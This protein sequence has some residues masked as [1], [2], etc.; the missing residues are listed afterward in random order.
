MIENKERLNR[1]NQDIEKK[2][3]VLKR[4]EEKLKNLQDE[5]EKMKEHI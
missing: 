1:A 4:N 2:T 3:L 5:K